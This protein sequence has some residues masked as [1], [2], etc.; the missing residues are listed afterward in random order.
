V[1]IKPPATLGFM[2]FQAYIDTIKAKTG[3]D[4]EDFRALA[5]ARG[6]LAA[7]IKTGQIVEWLA[8][9]FGLGR[10]HAMALVSTFK[11]I[12]SADADPV[13]VMAAH[14]AGKKAHWR[15]VYDSLLASVGVFG[16]VRT[17][18][19]HT[20]ISL[21]KGKAK[22]AVVAVTADRLDLG[23]KLKGVDAAG[24]LEQ[25]GSWNS[26]VTHRVRIADAAQIDAEVLDWLRRAYEAA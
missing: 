7:D 13:D 15:P 24:R 17:Q 19:T 8:T 22:F 25:S 5:E 4:P 18:A 10:G 6:L 2:S 12:R 20:Y 16:P 1:R 21:L 26:M 11:N 9:D 14:F 23:I 3:L